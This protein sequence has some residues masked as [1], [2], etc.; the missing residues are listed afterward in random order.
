MKMLE[1]V[2]AVVI[3]EL[4]G[5]EFSQAYKQSVKP[6]EGKPNTPESNDESTNSFETKDVPQ[7][8]HA[9]R[10]GNCS[11]REKFLQAIL[12]RS[13]LMLIMFVGLIYNS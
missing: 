7:R 1:A 13:W 11:T 5:E 3:S 9:H 12:S 4:E 8:S 10:R 2:P 6:D